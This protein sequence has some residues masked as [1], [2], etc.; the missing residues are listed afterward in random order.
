MTGITPDPELDLVL[1]RT[2]AVA[3]DK[4]WAAWT[5]PELIVRWFTP[6]PWKT[7][8]CDIDVRPGGRFVTTM[9]SPEGDRYLNAGCIV[10]VDPGRRLVFT[11]VLT[12]DFRP[13][14]PA[15]GADDLPFTAEILIEPAGRR[16]YPLPGGGHAPGQGHLR[17]ARRHGLPRRLGRRP[18]SARGP[19]VVIRERRA[20]P[21]P[22][23]TWVRYPRDAR[24]AAAPR[25]AWRRVP[26]KA[27]EGF[28]PPSQ[29][30]FL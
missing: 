8:V 15:N 25:A 2:I 1:D 26:A 7:V 27:R 19:D 10:A 12:E 6:A 22:A 30:T 16:R 20:R 13:V 23:A 28:I 17:S 9:E 3:P 5:D 24:P 21:D 14:R 4:V 18:R 29:Y 11:S